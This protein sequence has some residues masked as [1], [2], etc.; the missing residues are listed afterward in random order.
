ML[1]DAVRAECL[2]KLQHCALEQLCKQHGWASKKPLL[3][4]LLHVGVDFNYIEADSGC[5]YEQLQLTAFGCMIAR[6][7]AHGIHWLVSPA[8]A[9]V[10]VVWGWKRWSALH[11]VC[12]RRWHDTDAEMISTLL[13][14]GADIRLTTRSGETVL[15]TAVSEATIAVLEAVVLYCINSV[16]A[17]QS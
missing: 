12:T 16:A 4:H 17:D 6:D 1:L 15:H 14:L 7:C 11:A 10:N 5:R 2:K 8:G 9:D 3:E 13:N